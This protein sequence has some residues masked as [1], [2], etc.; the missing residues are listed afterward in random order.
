VS[1]S[2]EVLADSPL[3]YWTLNDALGST[4]VAD[5]SGNGNTGTVSGTWNFN[6]PVQMTPDSV[7]A[8]TATGAGSLISPTIAFGASDVMVEMWINI[9]AAQVYMPFSFGVNY[10]DMYLNA[11]RI[12]FNTGSGD[13]FGCTITSGLHHIVALVPN[14]KSTTNGKIYIDGALKALSGGSNT[15]PSLASTYF[16]VSGWTAGGLLIPAGTYVDEVAVYGSEL[17]AARVTAHY[18]AGL[19]GILT[20][21]SLSR[22][23]VTVIGNDTTITRASSRNSV[24]AIGN[25]QSITRTNSRDTVAALGNDLVIQRTV[26]RVSVQALVRIKP[27]FQGWGMPL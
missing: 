7:S 16:K 8:S 24:L 26:S 13:Q 2:S 14:N 15:A 27:P 6:Q 25:D 22:E 12:G 11:G 18:N 9:D 21:S 17:S 1:Y 19:A 10:L 3:I 23:S 20:N 4:T 5:S